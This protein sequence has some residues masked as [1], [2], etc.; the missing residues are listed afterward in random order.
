MKNEENRTHS[1]P[2]TQ[3]ATSAP[4]DDKTLRALIPKRMNTRVELSAVSFI[5]LKFWEGKW[6]NERVGGTRTM[7]PQH[8]HTVRADGSWWRVEKNGWS[9]LHIAF[10]SWSIY[11]RA[12][13]RSVRRVD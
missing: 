6:W 1:H 12:D 9:A 13:L 5:M 2:A 10:G 3:V 4:T 11:Q 8:K 7:F